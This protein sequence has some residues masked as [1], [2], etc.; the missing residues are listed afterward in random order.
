[1]C[2]S[3][4]LLCLLLVVD[5]TALLCLRI[6][7]SLSLSLN[8]THTLLYNVIHGFMDIALL[9]NPFFSYRL[10]D[11]YTYT[12]HIFIAYRRRVVNI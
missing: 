2:F 9:F 8:T 10:T 1:M 4:A 3:A 11:M 12:H 5:L 7:L 6:S